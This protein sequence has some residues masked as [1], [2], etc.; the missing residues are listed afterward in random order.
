MASTT[1]AQIDKKIVGLRSEVEAL[2]DKINALETPRKG[3]EKESLIAKW[4][5]IRKRSNTMNECLEQAK[6][7]E[8]DLGAQLAVAHLTVEFLS[9]ASGNYFNSAE[10]AHRA[11]ID[12]KT[13]HPALYPT[14]S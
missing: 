11:I 6:A 12:H 14:G 8:A 10:K 1:T 2:D 5:S 9:N 4:H 7:H 3:A 13:R